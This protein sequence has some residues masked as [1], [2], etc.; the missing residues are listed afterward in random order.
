MMFQVGHGYSQRLGLLPPNVNWQQ[1]KHDSIRIIYP[2]GLEDQAKRVASLALKL[3]RV[4]P[5]RE[6]SRYKP[7]SVILQPQTNISNGYVGLAPYVSEFY[8]EPHENPFELGS[9]PWPDLLALHEY[10]HVLQVNAANVG[11]SHFMK[12]IFGDLVFSGMYSL[13]VPNWYRE[14]DAVFTESKW[15]KQGRGRLSSFTLPFYEKALQG[16]AWNYYKVRN[17]S[18]REFTPDYYA[19]GYMMIQYGNQYFGEKMG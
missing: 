8:L 2:D 5:I 11:L 14:G 7:I 3:A 10:Q 16:E 12:V 15:S 18:Y 17:G 4:D 9:L 19:L 6:N 13:A 1:L